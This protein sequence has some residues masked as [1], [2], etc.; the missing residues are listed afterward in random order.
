MG[1]ADDI[2]AFDLSGS[3]KDRCVHRAVRNHHLAADG[4]ERIRVDR[5]HGARGCGIEQRV[6]GKIVELICSDV[7]KNLR[8]SGP[9]LLW[10]Y[11]QGKGR[12]LEDAYRQPCA[13][14]I[15]H[16]HAGERVRLLHPFAEQNAYRF[17]Q[18]QP[19]SCLRQ[20][21]HDAWRQD[22]HPGTE[23][24]THAAELR[25][26]GIAGTILQ[27]CDLQLQAIPCRLRCDAEVIN[28]FIKRRGHNRPHGD[29]VTT[30]I[31]QRE[32][33]VLQAVRSLNLL[34]EAHFD[35]FGRGHAGA[36]QY[37]AEGIFPC[38][39]EQQRP[40]RAVRRVDMHIPVSHTDTVFNRVINPVT[41]VGNCKDAIVPGSDEG[42]A[43]LP[44]LTGLCG[45]IATAL[46]RIDTGAVVEDVSP[47]QRPLWFFIDDPAGD[48][49]LIETRTGGKG[50]GK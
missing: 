38:H 18:H 11:L 46:A 7:Q 24:K 43:E 35:D 34:I 5:A 23:G 4:G 26:H 2:P 20:H 41:P 36:A 15:G 30:R 8:F 29:A 31:Q 17:V 27:P 14:G 28:L 33:P 47:D 49:A 50:Q 19:D 13:G 9:L 48:L 22:I 10:G 1:G 37:R 42:Y 39:A 6:A 21:A 25:R 40:D 16:L 3:E 32:M 44:E 12:R 45:I